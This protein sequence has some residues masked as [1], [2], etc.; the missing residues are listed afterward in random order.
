MNID[1]GDL[2]VLSARRF[3]RAIRLGSVSAGV[4]FFGHALGFRGVSVIQMDISLR[5]GNRDPGFAEG[6]IDGRVQL[7]DGH[8]AIIQI[9]EVHGRLFVRRVTAGGAAEKAGL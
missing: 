7:G 1:F 9:G 6:L 5:E 3:S 4:S 2:I 8:Q